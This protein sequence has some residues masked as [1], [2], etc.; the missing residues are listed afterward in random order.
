M[1]IILESMK[2]NKKEEIVRID[3]LSDKNTKMFH[4][5]YSICTNHT[6]GCKVLT[7]IYV[8]IHTCIYG[9]IIATIAFTPMIY[10]KLRIVAE[11]H[12][13]SRKGDTRR[14]EAIIKEAN[15]S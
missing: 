7:Y 10:N 11:G 12:T 15:S 3:H 5:E 13:S 9:N 14:G 4:S 1:Q 8:Y 6:L 2:G